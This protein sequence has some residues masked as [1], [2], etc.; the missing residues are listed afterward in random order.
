MTMTSSIE[1]DPLRV[2]AEWIDVPSVT[3]AEGDYGD[4]VGRFLA[5]EGL[6]V[7][8]QE[9]APGRFNVL[10]RGARPEVVFC[11]HLDTVPPFFGPRIE[12]GVI[13]G[14]GACDAKGQALAMLLAARRLLREGE[15]RIGFLLTVGEETDSAGARHADASL[16][17]PWN[18]RYVVVGEPT[19]NTFVRGHKGV[20][21][22]R[23]H[24]RG[25]AGHSSQD[26]GPSAIHELVGALERILGA[27]WGADEHFGR[28]TVNVGQV[29]GGLAANVVAPDAAAELLLRIVED[30]AAVTAR[31]TELLGPHVELAVGNRYG[32]LGFHVPPGAESIAV[33]F[34]TD[35]PFL[36]RWGTPLLFGPGSILDAHTADEKLTLA[37]LEQA[38]EVHVRTARSL[39]G[40]P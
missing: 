2:L 25:V 34:G 19:D 16:A 24:A 31:L 8:Q 27:D 11:T 36:P 12:R 40:E 22:C 5:A 1:A 18:P 10:A 26:V 17:D 37:S 30:P 15:E 21:K 4:L 9:L 23:L 35:A 32:P 29:S 14:R 6:G 3:G 28:G 7:E 33:A 20:Y 38:V 39:L 13:H